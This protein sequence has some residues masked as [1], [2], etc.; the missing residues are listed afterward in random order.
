M[1]LEMVAQDLRYALRGLRRSPGF[2]V[3]VVTTLAL[4]LGANVAMFGIV[5]RLLVRPPPYLRDAGQV[6]RVYLAG[7]YQGGE[8]VNSH[9]SYTRYRDLTRWSAALA[10]TAAFQAR[11]IA[12]GSGAD[13]RDMDVGTVSA[14]FF[15]FF[16]A[17]PVV[18]RFFTGAGPTRSAR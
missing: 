6:H 2:T 10:Q 12:V 1:R 14:S 3:A 18:G 5:D 16:A 7:R 9:M 17:R 8:Y 15:D 11:T 4:G 13:T